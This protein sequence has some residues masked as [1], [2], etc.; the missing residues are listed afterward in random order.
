MRSAVEEDMAALAEL[1][2]AAQTGNAQKV[3]RETPSNS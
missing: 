3:I 1:K 2:T